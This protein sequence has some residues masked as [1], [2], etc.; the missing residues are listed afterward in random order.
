MREDVMHRSKRIASRWAHAALTGLA[1]IVALAAPGAHA[2]T[3]VRLLVG[4]PAGG[5]IDIYARIVNDHMSRS[6]GLPVLIDNK[7]GAN[8][9]I[10]PQAVVDGP[11]DGNGS[12]LSR[13]WRSTRTPTPTC[14]G[15]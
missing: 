7:P 9:N 8:G 14:V 13:C 5:A 3:S 15:R 11:A 6:L 1:L 4:S 10:A 2:Q 12:A